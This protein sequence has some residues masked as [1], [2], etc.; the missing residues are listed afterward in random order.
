MV[1]GEGAGWGGG[2]SEEKWP[3]SANSSVF[4]SEAMFFPSLIYALFILR[5]GAMVLNP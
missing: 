3:F 5:L 4:F 1:E 2:C